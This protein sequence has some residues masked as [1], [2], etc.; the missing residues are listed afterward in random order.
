MEEGA[1][2]GETNREVGAAPALISVHPLEQSIVLAVGYE[3]RVF[4][5]EMDCAV[6]LTDEACSPS[7]SDSIR[8]ICF[9]ANGKLFVSAGDDKLVKIW[10]T[11]TWHCIR[12]VCSDKRVSAVAISHDGLF[13]TFADKFG[14]VWIVGLEEDV[15]GQESANKKAVPLLG[16]YCSIITS[17]KF[18]PDGQFIATA[19]RDF[20][21]RI[22]VFP[23]E[24][25]KGAHEIQNF[26]LGHTDFVSCL[27]FIR[28]PDC[29]QILLLSGG[30]D[31]TIRL[32]DHVSGCLL[33][34]FD[35]GKKAGLLESKV[36]DSLA[37]TD[38]NAFLD[39]SLVFAAI[40]GLHGVM[41]LKIDVPARSLSIAKIVFMEGSFV[42]TSL[43]LS[44]SAKRL[45]VVM[46]ASNVS[47]LGV[48]EMARLQV[49]SD[50][51]KF[52]S[53]EPGDYPVILEN[54][55]VPGGEKLLQ[56]LQDTVHVTK[57]DAALAATATAAVKVAMQNL[58]TKKQYSLEKRDFRKRHR[59]DRKLKK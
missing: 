50:L 54:E 40:Q 36:D 52:L 9:G 31:A 46:G 23:K 15:Q 8:A 43:G 55:G 28:P 24:H 10:R 27:T 1:Q 21:I 57:K 33:H 11:D 18:S 42:P 22:S 56:K 53:N 37:V 19:D 41:I 17:L 39:G 47:K 2:E 13:V 30:G 35:V 7:H 12:T 51:D 4:D 45:W 29:H 14:V 38:I 48:S 25:L 16:H 3:L 44:S 20:K 32:W 34:T 26:C 49:L 5:L 59:N 6:S 58:L